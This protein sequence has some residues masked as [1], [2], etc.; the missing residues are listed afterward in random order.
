MDFIRQLQIF[1]TVVEMGN[2]S[3]AAETLHMARP[4]NN[5]SD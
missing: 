5:K 2:F 4:R 1:V 3:R